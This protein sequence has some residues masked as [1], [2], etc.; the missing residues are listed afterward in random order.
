MMPKAPKKPKPLSEKVFRTELRATTKALTD[1]IVRTNEATTRV[2]VDTIVST[3][4]ELRREF[5]EEM[6][7]L[8]RE[9][10]TLGGRIE[11]ALVTTGTAHRSVVERVETLEREVDA[12]K[13]RS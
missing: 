8:R 9:I 1:A 10:V 7:G 13:K 12:L 3:N 2:L 6:T 5:R 4:G 11:N